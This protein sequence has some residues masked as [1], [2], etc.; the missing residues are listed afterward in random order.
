[1]TR[2][3]PLPGR[4]LAVC[5]VKAITQRSALM[6]GLLAVA[7]LL[8]AT[9]PLHW[10]ALLCGAV[11][12]AVLIVIHP[13]LAL[14]GLAFAIPFGSLAPLPLAGA[15][16]V[17][18]L[19]AFSVATWLARGCATRKITVRLPALSWPLLAF[20]WLAAWSL[21]QALSWREGVPELL[22]WVEFAAV[23][24]VAAQ[25]LTPSARRWVVGALLGAGAI[26]AALGAYQFF[27]QVGPEPFVVLGRFLR[28]YGT[29]R[30]P[31]PYAGYLGYLFPV[32]LSLALG[33]GWQWWRERKPALLWLAFSTAAV[34]L[35][36]AAGIGMSWSRG[37][38][39]GL[40]A[41]S[42]AVVGL[43][44]RRT[45]AFAAIAVALLMII[46]VIFGIGWLPDPVESRL[47][48]LGAYVG[49]PDPARTEITDANFSVLERLAHWRAGLAMF[50]DHPWLGVG[51][52]NFAINYPKYALP[53]WYDPL[54]HAHNVAINFLAETGALGA[55]AFGAFWLGVVWVVF[56]RATHRRGLE[57][58][59][60]IG[61]LGAWVYLTVHSMFDN[62]F[63]QHI[64]LQLALLLGVIVTGNTTPGE[65][66]LRDS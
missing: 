21:T 18:V 48:D 53:H 23:Y 2:F 63:V 42:I 54:G 34:A 12:A 36:L 30:Q 52:G 8:F 31:N 50:A 61:V 41:A 16:A 39:L 37:A 17:D 3:D 46:G 27:R 20:I 32:A 14:A 57:R 5:P 33:T 6:G 40:A 66:P 56:W 26:Q 49:G 24:L 51:I 58:A 29:F 25:V 64:Q 60:A 44:D 43:R 13:A 55:F 47:S 62:L 38:W 1:M 28:A 45:A 19:V 7:A 9:L 10:A 35:A 65:T 15:N 4:G 11:T 22:K 59:L